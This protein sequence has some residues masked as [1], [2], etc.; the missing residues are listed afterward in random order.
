[1]AATLAIVRARSWEHEAE[2]YVALVERLI[3]R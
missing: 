3:R 1:V 2:T